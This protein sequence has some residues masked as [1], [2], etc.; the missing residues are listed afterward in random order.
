[1]RYL[2][3]K[4][5]CV[6]T[7]L[8]SQLTRSDA[9]IGTVLGILDKIGAKC[10]TRSRHEPAIRKQLDERATQAQSASG[11]HCVLAAYLVVYLSLA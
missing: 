6:G 11:R 3:S 9:G 5:C 10:V 1:M 2:C 8:E 4:T 7:I